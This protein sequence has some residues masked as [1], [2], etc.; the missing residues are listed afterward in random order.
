M[1]KT[2]YSFETIHNI[3]PYGAD[4]CTTYREAMKHWNMCI[5]YW[6]AVNIYKRFPSKKYRTAVT[7][8]VSSYWH[9]VYLG[10][11]CCIG[12][13]PFCL[14]LEDVYYK[15]WLKD[16]KGQVNLLNTTCSMTCS[17]KRL[18]QPVKKKVM[19]DGATEK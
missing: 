6:L 11:Y 12:T 15:F 2:D 14:A 16:N 3:S 5:Q 7:M 13:V 8:L 1:E 19:V 17:C 4:F 18:I 9:G 10:Y